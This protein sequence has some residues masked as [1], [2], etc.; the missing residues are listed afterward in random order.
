MKLNTIINYN[1]ALLILAGVLEIASCF[2]KNPHFDRF[3]VISRYF[4]WTLTVSFTCKEDRRCE[5]VRHN[6]CSISKNQKII[7]AKYGPKKD[8]PRVAQV[9]GDTVIRLI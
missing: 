8:L 6:V 1:I 2:L 9:A 4:P 5:M 7:V 3:S